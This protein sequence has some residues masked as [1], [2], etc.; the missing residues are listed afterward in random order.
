MHAARSSWYP[1]ESGILATSR[2]PRT[3]MQPTTSL[4]TILW[5]TIESTSPAVPPRAEI[6][7]S[8]SS[9]A[10]LPPT[11]ERGSRAGAAEERCQTPNVRSFA[12]THP[13]MSRACAP[14]AAGT[15]NRLPIS[16]TSNP[17]SVGTG[18]GSPANRSRPA[19]VLRPR[20][21]GRRSYSW[22]GRR[23]GTAPRARCR[24]GRPSA[25]LGSCPRTF[26]A[27]R[28]PCHRCPAS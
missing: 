6:G 12:L 13:P 21:S 3:V 17:P 20:R 22:R 24:R 11:S 10:E 9:Y 28:R 2:S 25:A 4:E 16:G 14:R 18:V 15:V 5:P 27:Q 23:R 7:P 8:R 19:I 1:A 26:A